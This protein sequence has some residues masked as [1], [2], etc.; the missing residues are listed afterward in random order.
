MTDR[1][2]FTPIPFKIDQVK[3][4]S[5]THA[6]HKNI[7]RGTSSWKSGFRDFDDQYEMTEHLIHQ[8]NSHVKPTDCLIHH[9]D[10]SFGGAENVIKFRQRLNCQN[11]Y[12]MQGNHDIHVTQGHVRDGYF[13]EYTQ[14]GY[15][16]VEG[17]KIVSG[18]FPY[19]QWYHKTEGILHPF[20]HVHGC[21]EQGSR[22]MDVGVDNAYKIFGEYR[23]FYLTEFIEIVS[24]K[25][26]TPIRTR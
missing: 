25:D 11:I 1:F 7:A 22:S 21:F 20:G 5:D 14:I 12:L 26:A 18:H 15:Y 3:L 13:K 6:W 4:T 16:E 10:W 23:P 2:Q 9:G 17:I 24:K 8:I 19:A